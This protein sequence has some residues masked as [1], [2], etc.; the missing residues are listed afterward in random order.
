MGWHKKKS[1]TDERDMDDIDNRNIVDYEYEKLALLLF[2]LWEMSGGRHS[3]KNCE[4]RK[5]GE[6]KPKNEL[7][8]TNMR[9]NRCQ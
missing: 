9:I 5:Y 2:K 6:I 7:L 4:I 1:W 8:C 3:D